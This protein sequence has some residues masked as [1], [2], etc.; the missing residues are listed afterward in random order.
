MASL[1]V[2]CTDGSDLSLAALR[3]GL[4]L[5]APEV[6]PVLVTVIDEA[7]PV[8]VTGTGMAGGVL[9]PEEFDLREFEA[10]EEA[11]R[12]LAEASEALGL[13]DAESQLLRGD[14]GPA[15]CAFAASCAA[16]AIVVGSRG[17]GGLKR[18][19]LGSV[20]DHIVRHAPCTVVV[21]GAHHE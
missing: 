2:L 17:R 5:L 10:V 19:V 13:A 8:L 9:S 7:D 20:S 1:A 12:V 16:Q 14:P 18:A 6:T 15:V 21:T 3:A 11:Q 4:S